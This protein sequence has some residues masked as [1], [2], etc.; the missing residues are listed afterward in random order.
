M[1]ILY[2]CD[3]CEETIDPAVAPWFGADHNT[4]EPMPEPDE[5]VPLLQVPAFGE[6][7]FHFCSAGCLSAWAFS[8]CLDGSG[9]P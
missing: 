9:A 8:R 2:R 4:H 5:E 1:T 7:R 3:S 6:H